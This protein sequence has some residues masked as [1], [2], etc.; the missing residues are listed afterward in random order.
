MLRPELSAM[1]S[2]TRLLGEGRYC[3]HEEAAIRIRVGSLNGSKF[4][5]EAILN[6]ASRAVGSSISLPHL[7][8]GVVPRSPV[9]L[10]NAMACILIDITGG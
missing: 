4:G 8:F 3:N 7:C 6:A 9:S 5:K 2:C 1:P 10:V